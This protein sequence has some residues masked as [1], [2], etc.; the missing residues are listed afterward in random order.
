MLKRLEI[1]LILIIAFL[2]ILPL[3]V[4]YIPKKLQEYRI[5]QAVSEGEVRIEEVSHEWDVEENET[6]LLIDMTIRNNS[7]IYVSGKLVFS[8]TLDCKGV[9]EKYL[10]KKISYWKNHYGNDVFERIKKEWG[11]LDKKDRLFG[12]DIALLAYINRGEKLETG[13]QYESLCT[14]DEGHLA[15]I[16]P[17]EFLFKFRKR[18]FLPP[19]ELK[20]IKHNQLVPSTNKGHLFNIEIADIEFSK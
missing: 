5:R 4:F 18:V 19:G 2:A 14:E 3:G 8:V 13:K 20:Q 7:N 15:D 9:E 1:Q 16:F 17:N 12:T 11:K 6:P 10:K